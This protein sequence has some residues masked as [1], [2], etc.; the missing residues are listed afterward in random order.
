MNFIY[1]F[2]GPVKT[3]VVTNGATNHN[4][5]QPTDKARQMFISINMIKF[6]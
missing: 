3:G 2:G 4:P 1:S 6:C 5:S